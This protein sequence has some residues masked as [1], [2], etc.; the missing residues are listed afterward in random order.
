[1][2]ERSGPSDAVLILGLLVLAAGLLCTAAASRLLVGNDETR[3]AQVAR[4]MLESGDAIVLSKDGEMY[5]EKP[6]LWF[7]GAALAGAAAGGIGDF[8]ARLP[9]VLSALGVLLVVVGLGRRVLGDR[10]TGVLAAALYVLSVQALNMG[11]RAYLDTALTLFTTASAF[12]FL[13]GL[14]EGRAGFRAHAAGWIALG[15]GLLTKGP[16]AFLPP[17]LA[18]AAFAV[19]RR[20][21]GAFRRVAPLRG[22]AVALAV[23][24]AWFVPWALRVGGEEVSAIWTRQIAGRASASHAH[25]QPPWYFLEQFPVQFLPWTLLLP[26]LVV[27]WIR[28]RRGADPRRLVLLL[29]FAGGFLL[30]SLFSGKRPLYLLPFYPAACL[31]VADHVRRLDALGRTGRAAGL[32]TAAIPLV[33]GGVLVGVVGNGPAIGVAAAGAA[34]TVL[35]LRTVRR[36]SPGRATVLATAGLLLLAIPSA[37]LLGPVSDERQSARDLVREVETHVRDEDVLVRYQDRDR[38][39][40]WY[41]GRRWRYARKRADLEK[42]REEGPLLI[43]GKAKRVEPL[44]GVEIVGRVTYDGDAWVVA[45]WTDR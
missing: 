21:P 10:R 25:V 8:T 23:L 31:L 17:V 4:E 45:R 18:V 11:H 33:A 19:A 2:T 34:F 16:P 40:A 27:E 38:S 13:G 30:F 28:E 22:I 20:D 7:W 9:S 14:F 37:V 32:V 42:L 41:T 39:L 15:L 36:R 24:A 35:C 43:A 3:Y 26:T 29:W 12:V 44:E 1:V 6:P 5:R